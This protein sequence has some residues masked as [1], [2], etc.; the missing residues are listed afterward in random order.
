MNIFFRNLCAFCAGIL[1]LVPLSVSG[2]PMNSLASEANSLSLSVPELKID[3]KAAADTLFQGVS[4]QNTTTP[5]TY[6]NWLGEECIDFGPGAK[7]YYD[8]K[9]DLTFAGVPIFLSSFIIK[10][11]KKA[12]RSARFHFE[13][14]FRSEIDNYT[15]FAPYAL[16]VGM[17]AF[18]YDGRSS[19]DR[20]VTSALLSNA[21]MALAVN[22]TKYSVKEMRPDNSTENSFPSGHTATAFTAATILHKEY[23]LT[24][25]PW[26][27]IG[28]YAVAT[29]TGVMRVLNNRH[30]VSDVV[31]GA[32]IGILST[33]LG[34]WFA[35]M[36]Y[37]NKGITHLELENDWTNAS[38][39]FFD[40]QM[41]LG[42]HPRDI[43]VS[44]PDM[45]YKTHVELGT[46]TV[47]GVE[48]AFFFNKYIGV[49]GMARV[50][51]TPGKGLDLTD[52]DRGLFSG[53]NYVLSQVKGDPQYPNGLPGIYNVSI[54]DNNF[55]DASLDLG[56]Y[57][58]LPIG[59]RFA[60]DAKFLAGR[61]IND[62]ISYKG[63][64]GFPKQ[65]SDYTVI[66]N[67]G[68][69]FPMYY[70][71]TANGDEFVSNEIIQ[72]GVSS[73]YNYSLQE[74]G[75]EYDMSKAK[76]KNSWNWVTG[77]SLIYKYKSNFSWK[78]FADF[79]SSKTEYD[80]TLQDLSDDI[81]GRLTK[82]IAERRVVVPDEFKEYI[83][84]ASKPHT[85]HVEQYMN[86]LTLGASFSISF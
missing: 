53:I 72:P 5:G 81:A 50:T 78:I 7:V 25:S 2:A 40:I 80:Y 44:Y 37:K 21:V 79:D 58:N 33:E 10:E 35:D 28:G 6:R 47:F 36:I 73:M 24:R 84:I 11:K 18:G 43:E 22:A 56:I 63:V 15:Q 26:F 59:K 38:P 41:G 61:R 52:E 8:W 85:G 65:F 64:N 48:G 70:Y 62:G 42:M 34:Y 31:A 39:S 68:E 30:W 46:S 23:G 55:V 9:R 86:F 75:I 17:K 67:T 14:G 54:E 51:T 60:I 66:S 76:G 83:D 29:A 82:A 27:S 16:I 77:L 1:L 49:G 74:G 4:L 3:K 69:L 32:G 19:W 13:D 20:F 12:F 71:V 45:D 57:G